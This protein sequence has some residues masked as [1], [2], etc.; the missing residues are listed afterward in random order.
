[1]P[2]RPAVAPAAALLFPGQGV[3]TPGMGQPWRD[4]PAWSLV[5]PLSQW[6]GHDV[7]ELLLRSDADALRRTELGRRSPFSRCR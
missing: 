5:E 3:Q 4:A 7:A 6:S 2:G 1:V